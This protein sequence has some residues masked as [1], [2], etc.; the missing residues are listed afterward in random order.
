MDGEVP[1]DSA[2]ENN[3]RPGKRG[4]ALVMI[5]LMIV[6]IGLLLGLIIDLGYAYGQ[7]RLTQDL[8]DN[9]A[10]AGSLVIGEQLSGATGVTNGSVARA[11][12]DVGARSSGVANNT[13]AFSHATFCGG[14][15]TANGLSVAFSAAYL[16]SAGAPL[17]GGTVISNTNPLTSGA[18]GVVVTSTESSPTFF[19]KVAGINS[20][21]VGSHAATLVGADVTSYSGA[22]FLGFALWFNHNDCVNDSLGCTAVGTHVTFRQNQWCRFVGDH[23]IDTTNNCLGGSSFEGL[24]PVAGTITVGNWYSGDNGNK[25][26]FW[27]TTLSFYCTNHLQVV[28]PV[29]DSVTNAN[30][31]LVEV[32]GFVGLYL[33][34]PCGLNG[35]QSNR[36]VITYFTAQ[37]SSTSNGTPV[38]TYVPSVRP[39]KLVQ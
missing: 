8:S 18:Q 32:V 9:A 29:V 25:T 5:A 7:K 12:C 23:L 2:T 6:P 27:N 24:I 37:G 28:M 21:S 13:S 14:S 16:D 34:T 35:A 22:N 30:P 36:G 10:M 38:P 4:Q 26:G 33:D 20:I 1:Q 17:A 11:I 39:V 3:R 31:P 15:G 19:A